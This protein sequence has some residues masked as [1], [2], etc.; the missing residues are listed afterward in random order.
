[1]LWLPGS[2]RSQH[3]LWWG[4]VFL[5]SFLA[6]HGQEVFSPTFNV[7]DWASFADPISQANQSRPAWDLLYAL[8]FQQSYSPF[9]S[10]LL[11]GASLYGLAVVPAFF[12]PW[13]T[14]PWFYLLGL[15]IALHTYSLDLFNFSFAIGPYLLPAALSVLAALLMGYGPRPLLHKAWIDWLLGVL[16]FML[17]MGIYQP[18]GYVGI[19]I[20]RA[21]V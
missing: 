17:A 19:E 1:M 6:I 21:H 10:W 14:P 15:L 12:F 5:A 13:L 4:L 20:G 16:L 9:L 3:C 18:T 2:L 11:A 7:D 8:V